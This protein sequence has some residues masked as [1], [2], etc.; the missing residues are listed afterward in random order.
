TL[1]ARTTSKRS[2]KRCGS[3]CGK[4]TGSC[5]IGKSGASGALKRDARCAN[6]STARYLRGRLRA[7]RVEA[8][9]HPSPPSPLPQGER[10]AQNR[11]MRWLPLALEGKVGLREAKVGCG[12]CDVAANIDG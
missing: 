5:S 6:F 10:G 8:S 12:C 4:S 7:E 2:V 3:G 9:T 1:R 11:Y